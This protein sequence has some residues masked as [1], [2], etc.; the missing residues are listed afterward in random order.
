[1]RRQPT[2]THKPELFRRA[3]RPAITARDLYLHARRELAAYLAE[4]PAPSSA[5]DLEV[6]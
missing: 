1:M 3:E 5:A 4:H 6:R 2:A